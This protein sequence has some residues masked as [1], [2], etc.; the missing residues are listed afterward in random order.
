MLTLCKKKSYLQQLVTAQGVRNR[1]LEHQLKTYRGTSV[2]PEPLNATVTT[3]TTTTTTTTDDSIFRL[4]TTKEDDEFDQGQ[5]GAS[6]D[7][8]SGSSWL[9]EQQA[10]RGRTRSVRRPGTLT[11]V[12]MET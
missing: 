7:S 2:S 8:L 11:D 1:E 12:A 6:E 5:R 4:P 10:E 3:T 9:Q